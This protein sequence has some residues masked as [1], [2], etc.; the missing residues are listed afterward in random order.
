MRW[1]G[2]VAQLFERDEDDLRGGT[3]LGL[4][5]L[6]HGDSLSIDLQ[7]P[8]FGTCGGIVYRL[9]QL[10]DVEVSDFLSYRHRI[11][12]LGGWVSRN[13]SW[14]R[15]LFGVMPGDLHQ[16][17]SALEGELNPGSAGESKWR[18]IANLFDPR[19]SRCLD[20]RI[21]NEPPVVK[22]DA[23]DMGPLRAVSSLSKNPIFE[24]DPLKPSVL[25]AREWFA[26]IGWPSHRLDAMKW[27]RTCVRLGSIF[28]VENHTGGA[29]L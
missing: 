6:D 7:D 4:E 15:A 10:D 27:R 13:Q 16:R 14:R 17:F 29:R 20:R 5:D 9:G 22:T 12:I 18:S 23:E 21:P 11:S 28:R 3:K 2:G 26:D 25:S 19:A 1:T 8:S 24:L